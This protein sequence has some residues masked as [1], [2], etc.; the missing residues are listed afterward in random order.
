MAQPALPPSPRTALR[1]VQPACHTTGDAAPTALPGQITVALVGQPNVGKS[2]VFNMLTGLSQ[3]VGNWPGKTIEQKTGTFRHED[4]TF[5]IVDLP[6]TYSLTANSE[7]ERIARDYLL[8][9]RPNVV[10][11]VV[12]AAQLERSLYLV[13]ELMS[14]G[15]PL[16]LGLNLSDVAEQHGVRVE[17]HV[18]EAALG[19]PV[20]RLV[21]ARN[22]GLKQLVAAAR[23]VARA[24]ERWRPNPPAIRAEHQPIL[25]S[26]R[27]LIAPHTPVGYEAEW[28]AL[29]LLEG[30]SEL[31]ARMKAALPP[32]IWTV[33]HAVLLQHED[34]YLDIA[35]GR[36]EWIGRMMRAAVTTPRAGAITVTD[37]IDRF[38]THPVLGLLILLALFGVAFWLTYA[39][40]TPVAQWL[41]GVVLGGLT[42]VATA[43]LGTAPV[44]VRG[45]AVDGIING[46]GTVLTFLPVLAIFFALLAV[47]EDVGY[48]SRGA[49]V[50]DRFMHLMG[51]HGKSFM[52][53]FLGFGCNVPAVLGARIIEERRARFLTILLAPL[54]PCTARLA[55]V[56]FLAP[57][58]FGAGAALV[59][60]GIIAL[61]L[62][63][64]AVAGILVNRV[65]YKGE[66][67]AFIMELPL[68]HV[69]NLR[70]VGL[71]VWNNA[72]AFL[73]KAGTFILLSSVVVWALSTLPGGNIDTSIL[74][75]VGRW[76]QPLGRLMGLED[77]RV[78][79]ALLSSFFAK[80]NT[81]AT[82]G[83][84]F[85]APEQGAVLA[86]QVGAVLAPAARVAFLA[87][88]M[89]FIPCLATAATVKQETGSW[90][91]LA[92]SLGLLL[93]ISFAA[94]IL[95]YQIGVRL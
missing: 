61:N 56:A 87:V 83:V 12:N 25:D 65:A 21:A 30:D 55:V 89:L 9:E 91:W 19:V 46:A 17:P 23:D 42:T 8:R 66:Q 59:S 27:D 40:A 92:M 80:E 94:G 54:V 52:P 51:L 58:F 14:L 1:L 48:L 3:H 37:R 38:A 34:A 78:I 72:G 84:L 29:K 82:L 31:T 2:T 73:K 71:Y 20:V 5:R 79:V 44:W 88:A 57:A 90:R 47:L 63:V 26:L 35:G 85:G 69:P 75:T 32:E 36:Y 16:V 62:V 33:A 81:I 4:E 49:Y 95:I 43:L 68:Y 6:G 24:P 86:T 60:W 53:L 7:E 28:L 50:M 77:W 93:V 15:L 64:L 18:L 39:I 41:T 70:T 67:T 10:M 45:L 11:A 22:I 76:L 13:A 74:A